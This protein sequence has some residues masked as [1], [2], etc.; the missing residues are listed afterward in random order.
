MTDN[1]LRHFA[2]DGAVALCE[3]Y[4]FGHIN[5]TY[6]VVTEN[7]AWYILQKVN[8]HV[9]T[10][11]PALMENVA[12]VTGYLAQHVDDPRG[13][14]QLVHTT[15]GMPYYLDEAGDYWRVYV[16]IRDSIC[17]QKAETAED[18]YESAIAFGG[19][20]QLMAGFPAAT[21]HE[22]IP[23]FHNT[24]DRYAKFKAAVAADKLGRAASVQEEINFLL[25]R[26]QEMSTLHT[27]RLSGELP[28]RVTH[29]DTKLN[30][31]MLDAKTR[32]GLCV[33]DLDTVMPGL[34]LYDYG[35]SI[36][37]GA[38]TA[39]EDEKDAS[40]MGIDLDLF[41]VYTRGFLTAC[42]GLT[43]LEV[44]LMPLGAK[45]MTLECGMRFLTDYLDGDVYFAIHYP[46]HN[47]VRTHT[48]LALVADMEK[49]WDKMQQIV[50]EEHKK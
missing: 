28:L 41:R 19:F 8:H 43:E 1:V 20:Q 46:E 3:R 35:D 16:F 10:D 31:V 17:L 9:F 18:F 7:D 37:F 24:I 22:T 13:A 26:E 44:E 39:A 6:R 2:L 36:R 32:K 49:N 47:L 23:N 38:A 33:I 40:L 25:A 34:S 14:M 29:N 50:K 42:P 12:A 45:T 27:L 48:Q 21:L 5:E 11:V 30:N 15:E 4:G